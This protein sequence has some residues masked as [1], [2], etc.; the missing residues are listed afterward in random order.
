MM[1]SI[2]GLISASVASVRMARLPQAMSKPT[3]E[4]ETL[5]F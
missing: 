2:F 3:P 1:L 5:F 4:M